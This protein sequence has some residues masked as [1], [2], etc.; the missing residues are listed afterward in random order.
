MA[1]PSGLQE[2]MAGTATQDNDND[3]SGACH[4]DSTAVI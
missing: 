2:G 4:E 3:D 1:S